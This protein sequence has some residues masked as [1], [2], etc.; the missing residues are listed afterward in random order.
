MRAPAVTPSP[1]RGVQTVLLVAKPFRT[2]KEAANIT[3]YE[4]DHDPDGHGFDSD[5]YAVVARE[6]DELVADA[7]GND[8]LR[9]D[10]HGNVS[11]FHTFANIV[12]SVTTT[13]TAQWPGFD[14]SPEFPGA[15]WVPT[16]LALGPHGDVYVGWGYAELAGR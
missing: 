16:S 11:L 6:H 3:K 10:K 4:T 13:P 14:P 7:A 9:V 15:N 5:P 8:I 1:Q 2:P 12:N